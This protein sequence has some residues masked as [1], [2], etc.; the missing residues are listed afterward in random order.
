MP[1]TGA[2]EAAKNEAERAHRLQWPDCRSQTASDIDLRSHIIPLKQEPRAR[3][4]APRWSRKSSIKKAKTAKICR[5]HHDMEPPQASILL[6]RQCVVFCLG[7]PRDAERARAIAANG[8]ME[9]TQ[10]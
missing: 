1:A 2:P 3:A 6:K 4:Q 10:S 9:P 7:R 5:S 8:T